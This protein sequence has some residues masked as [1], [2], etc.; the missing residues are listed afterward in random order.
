M[1]D[2]RRNP[3]NPWNQNRGVGRRGAKNQKGNT[4]QRDE[5]PKNGTAKFLEAQSRLQKAVEKHVQ[6]EGDLSSEEEDDLET[7]T[8]LGKLRN[9]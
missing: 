1:S 9:G 7:E 3:Q 8:I 4:Q 2:P 5:A 6:Y